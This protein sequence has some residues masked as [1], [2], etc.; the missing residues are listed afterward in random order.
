[1]L[2]CSC[3]AVCALLFV[4]CCLCSAVCALL[5]V[6]Y[7][8]CSTVSVLPLVF[9]CIRIQ[10]ILLSLRISWLTFCLRSHPIAQGALL[11]VLIQSFAPGGKADQPYRQEGHHEGDEP[12]TDG[13]IQHRDLRPDHRGQKTGYQSTNSSLPRDFF[14]F[15]H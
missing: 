6:L 5:F 2:C 4:L 13:F 12:H 14:P 10:L 9:C 15:Q 11:P 7:R 3:S 1:M 8:S